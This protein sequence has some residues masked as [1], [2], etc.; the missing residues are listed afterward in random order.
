M[1]ERVELQCYGFGQAIG[2]Y[3]NSLWYY[4]LNVTR[5]TNNGAPNQGMLNAHYVND[6]RAT[7]EVVSGV[8]ACVNNRPPATP[9]PPTP[10]PVAGY[11]SPFNAGQR[12][13]DKRVEDLRDQTSVYTANVDNWY[14]CS[15]SSDNPYFAL[16]GQLGPGQYY[17][18]VGGWSLGRLGP[19]YLIQ[20]MKKYDPNALRTLNYIVLID[21]GPYSDLSNCDMKNGAGS[22]FADW[23]LKDN[24][25]RLVI[26]SGTLTQ[27]GTS[28]GIKDVYFKAIRD[29]AGSSDIRSRVQVCNYNIDHYRAYHAGQYWI[30]NIIAANT[31]PTLNF[32]G[33]YWAPTAAPWHP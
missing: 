21:P 31:C 25:A 11:Y 8:P 29:R 20:G 28:R 18:R 27:T 33:T 3:S 5:P 14:A 2:P 4:T 15:Q 26:L 19:S 1:N 6:G 24:D 9:T 10:S 32:E 22:L 12:G 16:K 23:L 13:D 7:N 30:K 17:D